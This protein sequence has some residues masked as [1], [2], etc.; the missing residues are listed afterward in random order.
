MRN[1]MPLRWIEQA[2][3][4][5]VITTALFERSPKAHWSSTAGDAAAQLL[6]R[7]GSWLAM[8]HPM[9]WVAAQV[10]PALIRRPVGRPQSLSCD[11]QGYS[12]DW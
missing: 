12:C 10:Q 1:A 9:G 11:D 5:Q 6:P 8:R 7:L 4:R 2:E 3:A